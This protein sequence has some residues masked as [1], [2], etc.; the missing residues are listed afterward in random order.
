MGSRANVNW[1]LRASAQG[2]VASQYPGLA[3]VFQQKGKLVAC[4]RIRM[5]LYAGEDIDVPATHLSDPGESMPDMVAMVNRHKKEAGAAA[6]LT[7][8]NLARGVTDFFDE[9]IQIGVRWY[10]LRYVQDAI[11]I[12]EQPMWTIDDEGVLLITD[13]PC[14]A[15]IMPLSRS[16]TIH[17]VA[18]EHPVVRLGRFLTEQ[19]EVFNEMVDHLYEA[20]DED[21]VI[22]PFNEL[23]DLADKFLGYTSRAQRVIDQI[24]EHARNQLASL[25][26]ENDK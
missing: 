4:D 26:K 13:G 24:I 20:I 10:V 6:A 23:A 14:T 21:E 12:M 3:G 25:E 8:H 15:M 11:S 17:R 1:L 7:L 19:C 18:P 5:H 22:D 9:A 16:A 2:I